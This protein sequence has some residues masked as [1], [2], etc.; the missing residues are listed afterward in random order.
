MSL[1]SKPKSPPAPGRTPRAAKA[2]RHR[3]GYLG[4]VTLALLA[5]VALAS[6]G[7]LHSASSEVQAGRAAIQQPS[8]DQPAQCAA[9]SE[10]VLLSP[11]A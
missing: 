1:S 9:P 5:L 2:V 10:P 8:T 11:K 7:F 3:D 4:G 6:V